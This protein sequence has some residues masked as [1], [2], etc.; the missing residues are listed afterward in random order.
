MHKEIAEVKKILKH[1]QDCYLHVVKRVQSSCKHNDCV[2]SKCTL[3]TY[4]N[5]CGM[6]TSSTGRR[7]FKVCK[8]CGYAECDWYGP[9]VISRSKLT[10]VS[11]EEADTHRIGPIHERD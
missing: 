3:K 6:G 8:D 2:I 7:P 10:Q 11:V 1:A 9:G 4:T 5:G